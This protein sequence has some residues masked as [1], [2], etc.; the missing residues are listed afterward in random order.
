MWKIPVTPCLQSSTKASTP[1]TKRV[2]GRRRHHRYKT[3]AG[4]A[5]RQCGTSRWVWR[6]PHGRY[7]LVDP[8]GTHRLDP[9]H[10]AMQFEAPD[11]LELYFAELRYEPAA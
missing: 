7:Y 3:H 2:F 10:G 4:Y 8:T 6:T 11:G 1:Q 5:A 9:T